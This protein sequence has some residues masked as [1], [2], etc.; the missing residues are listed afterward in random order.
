[1]AV[2]HIADPETLFLQPFQCMRILILNVPHIQD[3]I[4]L[5]VANFL[6]KNNRNQQ[7]CRLEPAKSIFS[8]VFRTIRFR[9][10]NL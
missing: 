10:C 4:Q 6:G 7:T 3:L 8:G 9:L 2:R 5:I 1:M